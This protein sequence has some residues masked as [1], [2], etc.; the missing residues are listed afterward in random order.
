MQIAWTWDGLASSPE[1]IG[2]ARPQLAMSGSWNRLVAG[3]WPPDGTDR[4]HSSDATRRPG[5]G[6]RDSI[7]LLRRSE[8]GVG[9]IVSCQARGLAG[10]L[11]PCAGGRRARRLSRGGA[12]RGRP[13]AA[14]L[15]RAYFRALEH[16]KLEFA[17]LTAV[18]AS[19]SFWERYGFRTA[20]LG[21]PGSERT[22]TYGQGARYMIATITHVNGLQHKRLGGE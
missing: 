14:A 8:A 17:C 20:E 5:V 9:P 2:C 22:A 12:R 10:D 1:P 21:E 3:A 7:L 11:L 13:S 6:A 15:I 19:G 4:R 18:N 16:S